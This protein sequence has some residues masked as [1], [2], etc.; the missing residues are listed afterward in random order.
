MS[1]SFVPLLKKEFAIGMVGNGALQ[2]AGEGG[3]GIQAESHTAY[4][5]LTSVRPITVHLI[6]EV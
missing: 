2:M 4:R 3:A 5:A 1:K 6:I